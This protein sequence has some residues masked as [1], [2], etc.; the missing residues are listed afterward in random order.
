M[1]YLFPFIWLLGVCFAIDEMKIGF[2]GMHADKKRI[3]Y[4]AEGDGFQVDA[5]CEYG[6]CFQFY[7]RNDPANVEYTMTGL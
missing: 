3:T 5:L 1:N 2:Q 7:F 6:F 4:K